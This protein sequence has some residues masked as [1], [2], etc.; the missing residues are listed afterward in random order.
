[1]K[2]IMSTITALV[3]LMGLA[4]CNVNNGVLSQVRTVQKDSEWWNDSVKMVTP[5]EIAEK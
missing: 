5:D 2:K 3:M 4:S 1:M